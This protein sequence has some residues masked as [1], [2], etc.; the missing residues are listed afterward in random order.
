MKK[1]GLIFLIFILGGAYYFSAAEKSAD[2]PVVENSSSIESEKS[3]KILNSVSTHDTQG[4]VKALP[5]AESALQKS[6]VEQK[7]KKALV[8]WQQKSRHPSAQLKVNP[9]ALH[10]HPVFTGTS[11]KIWLGAKAVLPE[12]T[13]STD[14]IVGQLGRYNLVEATNSETNLNQ[15]D[16]NSLPVVYNSRLKKPGLV[17]GLI[18]VQTERKDLLTAALAQERAEITN[19]F[20]DIQTYYVT[21]VQAQFDL[22]NL[23]NLIKAMPFVKNAELDI[24]DR[25]YEKK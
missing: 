16:R 8:T 11:W 18:Q 25:D 10:L 15:F 2:T 7:M 4:V 3:E 6:D 1:T 23:F 17:T 24:L 19:S 22:E 14:V 13:Q 12:V 21:S 20:D 9:T 5:S